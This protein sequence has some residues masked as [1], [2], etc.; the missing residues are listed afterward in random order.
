MAETATTAS[1][2]MGNNNKQRSTQWRRQGLL[3]LIIT[4]RPLSDAIAL[5]EVGRA[6]SQQNEQARLCRSL[7]PRLS[8]AEHACRESNRSN[9]YYELLHCNVVLQFVF[10]PNL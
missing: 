9:E 3:L 5:V 2:L 4:I 10:F 6:L 8:S 1:C 7:A